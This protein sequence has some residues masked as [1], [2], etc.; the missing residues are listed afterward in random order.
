M[1]QR[2]S[3]WTLILILSAVVAG[4]LMLLVNDGPVR[5][6][7]VLWFLLVCPG[8]ALVRF[9][10]LDEPLLV[11]VLAVTLSL[12]ADTFVGGVLLY[13]GRWAPS[14]AFAIL[15]AHTIGGALIH[16]LNAIRAAR[17]ALA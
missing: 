4:L 6:A 7:V 1:T 13:S 12:V 5:V 9:F 16:E 11:W 14:G 10:H 17:R 8:M 3:P 2:I 15:L